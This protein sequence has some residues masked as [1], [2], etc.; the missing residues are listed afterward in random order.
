MRL[1]IRILYAA[2]LCGTIAQAADLGFAV[3]G[4]CLMGSCPA[5]GLAF[6]STAILP[7]A[8]TITLPNGDVYSITGNLTSINNSTGGTFGLSEVFQ[9][10]FLGNGSGGASQADT[11]S[12]DV[13]SGFQS[14]FGTGNFT[15]GLAGSFSSNIAGS[16]TVET[17]VGPPSTSSCSAT[18]SP[19][20]PFDLT[21]QFAQAPSGGAF[22]FDYTD[23]V[24]FGAG[25]P[26]GSY[27]LFGQLPQG[28][29]V[30]GVVSASAFGEF[31]TVAPG[32]WI[33]IYGTNL[34]VGTRGWST[35][36]FGGV[37]GPSTLGGTS[38]TI[39]G[40]PAFVDYISPLQVNVQ[41]PGNLGTGSQP[42]VVA[43]AAGASAAFQVTVDATAPG[44]LAASNFKVNG[45]PYVVAQFADGTYVLP[46]GAVAGLTSRP[47]QPGD[48]IVIYGVGFGLV[49][50]NTPPGQLVQGL[51]TI[52]APFTI[53]FGGTQATVNYDGLAPNYMGLYQFNVVV[54]KVPA[55][56]SVPL[57]F[58]LNGVSGTQTL[59][60]AVGS[61]A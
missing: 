32:S 5:E 50:P 23:I 20:A 1:F 55:G 43:T 59:A 57:T 39:G 47:A 9:V 52:A 15:D 44:L 51:N 36:D 48:T 42:L 54:P 18:A 2:A 38:V 45:T 22:S 58:T 31:S 12:I 30:L 35:S 56:D 25:S 53:S 61:Q 33:E 6:N 27:V 28:P 29:Q 7:I 41:V 11:L 60:I 37:N 26:A 46:T 21:V 49:T 16:S 19:T 24:T 17:C 14:N 40:Q 13:L 4:T 3:N 8:N 10:I 34:A